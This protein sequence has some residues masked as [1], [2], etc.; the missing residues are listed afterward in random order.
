MIN[1]A[2][3]NPF[4][5][6][7]CERDINS[8][9]GNNIFDF[10]GDK[11]VRPYRLELN[12]DSYGSFGYDKDGEWVIPS[13]TRGDIARSILYMVLTYEINEL[14]D[15]HLQTLIHWAKVDSPQ[16]WELRYNEWVKAKHEIS[17]PFIDTPM[18]A[19]RL[20]NEK[21]LLDSTLV[22]G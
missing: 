15:E 19:L 6:A 8:K 13:H 9:R 18:Q 3:T 17:N 10:D 22:T 4:N 16:P 21:A 11:I 1:G 20:L 14:Y 2:T 12:P 5:F 7:A